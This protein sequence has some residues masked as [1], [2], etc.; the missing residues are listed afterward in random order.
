MP[1]FWK[2]L[3]GFM[4]LCIQLHCSPFWLSGVW[5]GKFTT[6]LSVTRCMRLC[7]QQAS[8][9]TC[10]PRPI[11]LCYCLLMAS[12]PLH[13]SLSTTPQFLSRH[14]HQTN[15]YSQVSTPYFSS[16]FVSNRSLM[17]SA[18]VCDLVYPDNNNTMIHLSTG[19]SVVPQNTIIS[20]NLKDGG[21]GLE[22]K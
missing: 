14:A 18:L 20:K 22:I 11:H 19:Y 13:W 1:S 10:R 15:K 8:A 5:V 9:A 16:A 6:V 21:G 4:S 12:H 2:L 3:F 7:K 17:I